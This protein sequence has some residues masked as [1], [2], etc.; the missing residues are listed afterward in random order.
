M[1]SFPA[2][3][4]TSLFRFVPLLHRGHHF[5]FFFRGRDLSKSMIAGMCHMSKSENNLLHKGK[6]VNS[7]WLADQ[8]DERS[9]LG[10]AQFHKG[11]MKGDDP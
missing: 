4:N 1:T 10:H 9:V 7:D 3:N 6:V 2:G 5:V 8:S 11:R